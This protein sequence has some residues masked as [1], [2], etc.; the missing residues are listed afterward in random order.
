MHKNNI[1][2]KCI[3]SK[4]GQVFMVQTSLPCYYGPP[5]TKTRPTPFFIHFWFNFITYKI[6][7]KKKNG[8]IKNSLQTKHDSSKESFK[9]CPKPSTNRRRVENQA[10]VA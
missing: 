4:W 2:Q 10:M 3:F 7:L 8:W 1:A 6:K 9:L 5:T